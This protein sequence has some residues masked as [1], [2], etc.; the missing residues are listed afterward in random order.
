METENGRWPMPSHHPK[1]EDYKQEEFTVL[2]HDGTRCVMEP[3]EAASVLKEAEEDEYEEFDYKV[4]TVMIT[5]DQ[6]N[7]LE[8]FTG[9]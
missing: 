8:E 6:F 1:C 3:H 5:R 2:E 4:S 9:F 7:K